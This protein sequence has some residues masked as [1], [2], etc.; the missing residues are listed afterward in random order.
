MDVRGP[1]RAAGR[2]LI[3]GVLTACAIATVCAPAAM[4]GTLTNEHPAPTVPDPT[5]PVP[6]PATYTDDLGQDNVLT[7]SHNALNDVT[8]G[9]EQGVSGSSTGL[10]EGNE[11]TCNFTDPASTDPNPTWTCPRATQVTLNLGDGNDTLALPEAGFPP[12]IIN[13][14]AGIDKLDFAQR[15]DNVAVRLDGKQAGGMTV[16]GGVENVTGGGADDLITGDTAVNQLI[17]GGGD[18]LLRGGDGRDTIAGQAGDDVIVAADGF[19]DTITC[20]DGTD[21]VTADL[22][23]NGVSDIITDPQACESVTGSVAAMTSE[24]TLTPVIV[25]PARPGLVPV[26]APGKADFADLTP[27]KAAMRSFTRQ[28]LATVLKRGVPIRV[29]CQEACGISIAL[30]LDRTTARR[31]KLDARTSPVVV[32]TASAVRNLAGSS[33][34]HVKFTKKARAA[35]KRSR[36]NVVA[37]AQVLVSDASG[38]GMLLTRRVTLVR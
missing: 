21:T 38:N 24:T 34:L 5:A 27:P 33:R 35:L 31:L 8:F 1:K 15:G 13:G 3:Q 32:G 30:S 2:R 20:G 36:R 37:T 10:A 19:V 12:L 17:G 18:D 11:E 6:A 14:G 23:A 26:L 22:G 4:A 9:D 25:V 28:R 29:T 16:N 7:L